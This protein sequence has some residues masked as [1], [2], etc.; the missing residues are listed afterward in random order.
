MVEQAN[1]RQ[2]T[3]NFRVLVAGGG[4]GGHVIPALA[5]ARE[6]SNVHGAT[7]HFVGTARGLEARLVPEAGFPLTLVRAGQFNKV[8][9]GTRV[10]TLGALP[11]AVVRCAA[12]MRQFKPH[13]VLGVGGY[14]SGPAMLA[15]LAL[16]VPMVAYE[17]NAIPGLVN[18]RVGR[19]VAN[20]AVAYPET[21]LYFRKA[22]VTGVPVRPEIFNIRPLPVEPLRLLVTAGSNGAKI[23][24]ET[25]PNI[26]AD[27]LRA[28]PGLTIM[29]QA[30]ERAFE[31][32]LAAYR[33]SGIAEDQVEVHAF[34][35][36]MPHQLDL[37]TLVLAR[38]GSTVAEL[39]AAGRPSLLV[40]FPL[41][42]DD[43]Q[44]RNALAM[45]TLGAAELLPQRELT[46]ESL[47]EHLRSLLLDPA[48]LQRM[49]AAGRAAAWPDALHRI[50][51]M[52]AVFAPPAHM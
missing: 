20:A 4:T 37:A 18:R 33:A 6:L 35:P 29:H 36:D 46:P 10:R 40:P 50:R 39:A 8:S 9:L 44:T 38:A 51:R 43:H 26:A 11:G 52:L 14:A 28:V 31:A 47:L 30:G 12:L 48:R 45:T 17:P 2:S 27:L 32:T 22:G 3:G 1:N 21:A 41:A 7:V 49:A 25:L 23:F 15:A 34:L 16:R 42:A 24:N 19:F 13:V 5:I